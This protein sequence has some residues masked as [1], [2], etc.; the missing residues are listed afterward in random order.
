M[1]LIEINHRAML[2]VADAIDEYCESQDKEMKSADA[3]MKTMFLNYFVGDDARALNEKWNGVS[4]NG[5]VAVQFKD[6]LINFGKCLKACAK[7]YQ[8]AQ[9]DSYN[10]AAHLPR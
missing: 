8:T 10:Q 4:E 6:S 5:S 2:E 1:A 3:S 7:E 9:E